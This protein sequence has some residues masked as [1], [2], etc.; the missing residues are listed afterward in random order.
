ME[1][2]GLLDRDEYLKRLEENQNSIDLVNY[3]LEKIE[4]GRRANHLNIVVASVDNLRADVVTEQLMPNTY[5]F[6]SNALTFSNHFS[7]SSNT[8]FNFNI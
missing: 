6:A 3:P 1:K 5:Q 7:S 4:F 8:R 2:H